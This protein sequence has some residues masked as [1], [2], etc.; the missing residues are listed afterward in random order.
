MV[1]GQSGEVK[2]Y[3]CHISQ[4][5]LFNETNSLD[6]DTRNIVEHIQFK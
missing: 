6:A 1:V 4:S 3:I 5:Y 2:V